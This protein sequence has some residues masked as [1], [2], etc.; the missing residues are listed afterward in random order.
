MKLQRN[1]LEGKDIEAILTYIP[2]KDNTLKNNGGG[3]YNHT[4]FWKLLALNQRK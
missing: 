2:A 4:L 1:E 3:H